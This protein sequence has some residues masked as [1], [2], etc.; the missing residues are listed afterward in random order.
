MR[1]TSDYASRHAVKCLEKSCQI[2]KYLKDLVFIA[3]NIVGSIK[4][5]D[6]ER[7]DIAMP[8]TQ[9]SAWKEVQS[10]DKMLQTLVELIQTGQTP[11]K[12]KTCNDYTTLKLLY[13]LYC[14]G[15]LEISNQGLITVKQTHETGEQLRA[16]V[17]PQNQ[18]PGLAHSIHLKTMHCSKLQLI[19]LMS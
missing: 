13:N 8:F 11:E 15:S 19:R 14:K 5:E 18:Y 1:I 6:I 4:V 17:V 9:Q 2:C 10:K 3:D 12:K 7:G 16:I